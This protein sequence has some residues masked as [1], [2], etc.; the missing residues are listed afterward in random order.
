VQFSEEFNMKRQRK[1]HRRGNVLVLTAIMMII[2]VGMAAFALDIGCLEVAKTQLQAATDAAALAAGWSLVPTQPTDQWSTLQLNARN[3]AVAYAGY[4]KIFGSAP[5]VNPNLL[6]ASN[7]DVVLGYIAN[8]SDPNSPMTFTDPSSYNA[9][10]VTVSRTAT[11]NGEVPFFFGKALGINGKPLVAKAT[12]ALVKSVA[13]LKAPANGSN[14]NLLPFALDLTTWTALVAGV[15]SDN[16]AYDA[17]HQSVSSG[18]DGILECNLYPQGTGSPGNRG[19]VDIGPCNNSTADIA[20]QIVYGVS[21]NDLSHVGGQLRFN[22]SGEL[23]LNGDTGI[24]AGVKDELASIIGQTRII[25]VFSTVSGNGNNADYTIVKFVGV[26]IMAV[27]LTGSMS[28]KYVM[29][30]PAVVIAGGIIP[31]GSSSQSDYVYSPVR[32]IR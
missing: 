3:N 31:G 5:A 20:R 1:R 13:G 24:S 17:A 26:R 30:Q 16:Y 2:V 29:I 28:S 21:A 6:N 22:D 11:T 8:I 14:L 12:A 4:N 27:K 25:P 7:G 15:G 32:L 18:H 10:Q 19:T 23:H 9:V